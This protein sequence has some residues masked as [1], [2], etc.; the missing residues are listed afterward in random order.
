VQQGPADLPLGRG[1]QEVAQPAR[2]VVQ[3]GVAQPGAPGQQR[4]DVVGAHGR[5][6]AT[7]PSAV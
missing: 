2:A 6:M 5:S 7:T 4:I 1:D 3:L